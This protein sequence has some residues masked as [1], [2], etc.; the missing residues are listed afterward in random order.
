MSSA[1]GKLLRPPIVEVVCGAYFEP[2]EQL[3]PVALG[4]FWQGRRAAYPRREYKAALTPS[5]SEDAQVSLSLG[6]DIG[7]LRTWLISADDVFILQVQRDRFYLNWRA[8][9]GAYPR[10]NDRDGNR[11]LLSKFLEEFGAFASFSKQELGVAPKVTGCELSKVDRLLQGRDWQDV[12]DLGA[13]LPTIKPSLD[14]ATPGSVPE[15]A[16]RLSTALADGV[17]NVAINSQYR[18]GP[19]GPRA[20]LLSSS[21]VVLRDL[22]S[23]A[24]GGAL[25]ASNEE[26]N[27]LFV[28]LVP[29][30][31]RFGRGREG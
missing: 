26:L 3:D 23:D 15:V 9:Q 13:L 16:V 20:I 5:L 31:D 6:P 24:V 1:I 12:R 29:E 25:Q 22:A 17:M 4:A 28:Q 11:G 2:V 21:R 27:K 30:Q 18:L 7:P 19:P 8:R 10:F 14:F